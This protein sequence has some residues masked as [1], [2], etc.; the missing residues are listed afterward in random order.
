MYLE[1]WRVQGLPA[2]GAV[3]GVQL[4]TDAG[5]VAAPTPS[6]MVLPAVPSARPCTSSPLR[7]SRLLV[8]SELI[9]NNLRMNCMI[10]S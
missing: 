7:L 9:P 6:V 4:Q 2:D 8:V 3:E 10:S 5:T 1:Y